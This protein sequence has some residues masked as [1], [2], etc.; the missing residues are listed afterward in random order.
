MWEC[1]SWIRA[2][3]RN[4][5]PDIGNIEGDIRNIECNIQNTVPDIENIEGNIRNTVPNI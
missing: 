3:T 2:Y 5:V 4:T 1:I